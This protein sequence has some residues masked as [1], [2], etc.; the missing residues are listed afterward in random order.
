MKK[1]LLFMA[2]RVGQ[3][4]DGGRGLWVN[5]KK[6]GIYACALA[7]PKAD[8]PILMSGWVRSKDISRETRPI[9]S[10]LW[11]IVS[12]VPA[13]LRYIESAKDT[14]GVC[15]AVLVSGPFEKNSNKRLNIFET[16]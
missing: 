4:V 3:M 15:G 5:L 14:F 8:N 6:N 7:M 1:V 16:V 9:R 10:I 2:L 12:G 11:V 13:I